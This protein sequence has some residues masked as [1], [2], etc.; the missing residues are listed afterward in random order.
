MVKAQADIVSA[1]I[2]V[3][4][5]LSLTATALMWGLPLIQKR[6]DSAIVAR[7]SNLFSQEL[8]S[9]IKYVANVGGSEVLSVD[10]N[11]IW[12]LDSSTNTLTFTFFS[13]VSDKAADI[14]WIGPNCI[15][16]GVNTSSSGT[17]GIDEPCLVCV[18]SDTT[19]TGY[20]ITYQLGCRQLVSETKNYKINLVSSGVTTST[21]KTIRISRRSVSQN[22][23]L[24]ITEI[25][26][27]L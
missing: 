3:L 6:Q 20:N 23:N 5:A 18:R 17:L 14:G 16:T 9:K 19:G 12:I 21:T 10:A 15:S 7:V 27:S 13:K 24:I 4:I 2:I 11:G 25:E 26:I 8:P 22:D 1:V